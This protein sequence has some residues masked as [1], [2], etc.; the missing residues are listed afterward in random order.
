MKHFLL[1]NRVLAKTFTWRITA[2][3]IT[4]AIIYT[5]TQK[6]IIAF[7]VA[8]I[9]Y[10][11]KMFLYWAHEKS[12]SFSNKPKKGSQQRSLIKTVTWRIIASLDTL[13]IV[14]V[15][16][17]E[18]MWASSAAIIESG[19]K[20]LGYYIHDRIWD[21]FLPENIMLDLHTH[22]TYSDGTV[23]PQEII[24]LA[25]KKHCKYISITDHDNFNHVPLIKNIPS[26][27]IY[28]P[29]V[30]ISA[31]FPST[32][33]ILGYAFDPEHTELKN[34][35]QTLQDVRKKRNEAMIKKME[36]HGF[37][38]R[39][40]ELIAE[41]KG[42]IIG[43]PHFA[44][45]ML[46]KGYVASYQEAFDTHLAK[47]KPLYMDKKR[48]APKEAIRLI[49]D[50]GGIPVMAHPYQTK[51]DNEEL[52]QLIIELKSYGLLGIEAYYSRHSKAQVRHYLHL[53][54][55]HD[56]LVT[57]GSDFHGKNKANITLGMAAKE[58]NLIP[59]LEAVKK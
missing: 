17:K 48:L 31:E 51:L 21:R 46:K 13:F 7:T 22:S 12:W 45:Q 36:T 5:L 30:E 9:E 44:N 57:A 33:H 54:K 6:I 10:F 2:S 28:I 29:G 38:I 19:V 40:D 24:E 50:A 16:T 52:E 43:R 58:L 15:L 56:L 34:T 47:G 39:M 35:L 11:T 4:I 32:L 27:I 59:F 26:N 25:S 18:P 1:K 53:A 42:G 14:M 41:S 20:T 23:A 55:K 3:L 37:H 49:L 8:G